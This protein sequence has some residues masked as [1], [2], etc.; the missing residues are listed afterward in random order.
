M[1]VSS[2]RYPRAWFGAGVMIA[3]I[4]TVLSLLPA[5]QLPQI[6]VS[7]KIRHA[8]AYFLLGFWF[9]SVVARRDWLFVFLGLLA[10]GGAI[11]IAQ[12]LMKLGREAELADLTANAAGA[13]LG[14]LLA[15]TPLG[16][17]PAV[18]ERLLTRGP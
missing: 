13:A 16:R 7:D 15:G 17:W 5:Q 8:F 1:L 10:L 6:G 9:A 18:F 3:A 14:I 12:G 4:I 2:L 11:E